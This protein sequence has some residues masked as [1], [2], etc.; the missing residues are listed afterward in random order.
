MYALYAAGADYI[1]LPGT[2]SKNGG[3]TKKVGLNKKK[4]EKKS[5][6]GM[7]HDTT[8]ALAYAIGNDSNFFA[9]P[10]YARLVK[11]L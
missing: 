2:L 5:D 9:L 1:Q 11:L 4:T 3:E 7:A 8:A 6:L 10:T